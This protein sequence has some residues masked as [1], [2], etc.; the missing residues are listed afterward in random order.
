MTNTK[1]Y[2]TL[3]RIMSLTLKNFNNNLCCFYICLLNTFYYMIE[4]RGYCLHSGEA[5]FRLI[6]PV[7]QLEIVAELNS[8]KYSN[9]KWET[10]NESKRIYTERFPEEAKEFYKEKIHE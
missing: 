4:T 10:M 3:Q 1:V 2:V 5:I 7:K 9:S 8:Q 6:V